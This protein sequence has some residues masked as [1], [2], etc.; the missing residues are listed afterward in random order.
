MSNHNVLI[1]D[2]H[3]V[4]RAGFRRFLEEAGGFAMVGEAGSG[5]ETLAKLRSGRWDLL[6]LDIHM[7]GRSGLDILER[8]RASYPQLRILVVS[9]LPEEQY[10]IHV[11]R[12]GANGYLSKGRAPEELLQAVRALLEGR[13]YVSSSV[14]EQM[15]DDFDRT[16]PKPSH[17][18]LSSR[19]F[20][21]FFKLAAGATIG[22]ISEELRLSAKTVSTYRA[23]ILA[24]MNLASNAELTRYA[25]QQGLVL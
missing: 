5:S 12:Q 16:T 1:A 20:Q 19:E 17:Q 8:A 11:I 3:A 4:A 22:A 7:R 2:D 6:M 13:T 15:I 25:Y 21:V 18:A 9:G 14:A 10:A 24:K 23:H